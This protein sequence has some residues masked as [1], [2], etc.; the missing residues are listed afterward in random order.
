MQ[1]SG[2]GTYRPEVD[3]DPDRGREYGLE[4]YNSDYLDEE[5]IAAER[6]EKERQRA[7]EARWRT[8]AAHMRR[9]ADDARQSSFASTASTVPET[10]PSDGT[11]SFGGTPFSGG[12]PS[13]GGTP[14]YGGTPEQMRQSPELPPDVR[15]S[16]HRETDSMREILTFGAESEATIADDLQHASQEVDELEPDRRESAHAERQLAAGREVRDIQVQM[17]RLLEGKV[18]SA[19]GDNHELLEELKHVTDV[20]ERQNRR[21]AEQEERAARE[22]AVRGGM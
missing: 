1:A 3:E 19:H 16:M 20:L 10:P 17:I 4:S 5:Q 9:L 14:F 7:A 13:S 21:V 22:E 2:S 6:A 18:A 11:R 15:S 12:T 8:E